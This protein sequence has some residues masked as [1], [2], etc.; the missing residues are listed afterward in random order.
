MSEPDCSTGVAPEVWR[1][2]H[3]MRALQKV[4]SSREQTILFFSLLSI[5]PMKSS[6]AALESA[7]NTCLVGSQT[8]R[9]DNK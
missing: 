1:Q 2:L 7:Q 9:C 3:E 5:L 8:F 4:L 6:I